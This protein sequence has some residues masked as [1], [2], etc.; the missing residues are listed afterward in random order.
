MPSLERMPSMS[1][2]ILL[3]DNEP[4]VNKIEPKNNYLKNVKVEF[5]SQLEIMITKHRNRYKQDRS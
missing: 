5:E 2:M 4:T 3:Q 1:T